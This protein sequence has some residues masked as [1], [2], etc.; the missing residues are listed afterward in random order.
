MKGTLENQLKL[1]EREKDFVF[2]ESSAVVWKTLAEIYPEL[3]EKCRD[4]VARGQLEPI[5]SMWC[6]PDGQCPGAESWVRH[7]HYGSRAAEEYMG[8]ETDIGFNID[9]FGF[10]GSLP[11]IYKEAGVNY[12]VTQKLRYNEYTLFPYVHFWWEA[13]DG[14]RILALHAYPDHCHQIDPDDIPLITRIV[15]LTDGFNNIP[16][17]FGYGNHGGGPLP[18]MM[19]RIGQLK[20]LTVYPELRYSSFKGYFN[21]I[22]IQEK[23]GL[24]KLPVLRDELFL[25][26]HHKTYT[27][28]GKIKEADRECER[29]LLSVE[30]LAAIVSLYGGTLNRKL[31]DE[32]WQEQLFNQF[33]DVVSGTSFPGVYQDAFEG[34]ERACK[35][36]QAIFIPIHVHIILI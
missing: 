20:K 27:V 1:M 8:R 6:E 17:M 23:N 34:Y 12:F 10:N 31:M 19:D 21:L 30:A 25:E 2:V 35:D 5:G 9:A 13:D 4:A 24:E 28:C 33:H 29:R 14:S 11:K 18:C 22:K 32:A 3:W 26:T 7:L 36:P 15:H 16:I